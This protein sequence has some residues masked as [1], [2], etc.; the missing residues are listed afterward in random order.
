VFARR[1]SGR[2]NRRG[3]SGTKVGFINFTSFFTPANVLQ[4]VQSDLGVTSSGGLVSAWADQSGNNK[5]YTS[6][7]ALQ[8]SVS[9]G[10]NGFP[11]VTFNTASVTQLVSTLNLPAPGTTPTFIWGVFR[12][13]GSVA[14]NGAFLGG[15]ATSM[16][17][18]F[19]NSNTIDMY[20]GSFG[21]AVT[22]ALNVFNTFECLF[23]GSTTSYVK[24][25]TVSNTGSNVGNNPSSNRTLGQNGGFGT[26]CEVLALVYL[27]A[28]PTQ[29][30]LDAANA[31]AN[32]KYA[33]SVPFGNPASIIKSV[34]VAH[35]W[36]ADLGV[37]LSS[38]TVAAWA[39]QIGA[40]HLLQATSAKQPAYTAVDATF[41][42][43]PTIYTNAA[44]S[45]NLFSAA[46]VDLTG[47]LYII[48]VIKLLGA[49]N[50]AGLYGTPGGFAGD[51]ACIQTFG[52]YFQ[53]G[54]GVN[55]NAGPYT[56]VTSNWARYQ[57]R[58]LN[59][60][61]DY[62][63]FGADAKVTGAAC[64]LTVGTANSWGI[65]GS[66]LFG[67]GIYLSAGYRELIIC[68]GEPNFAELIAIDNYFKSQLPGVLV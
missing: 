43:S 64:P 42:N 36:R 55:A 62:V 58:R 25:G 9:T 27:N 32:I 38:G 6:I 63:K 49:N 18:R 59:N 50:S 37:T 16:Y 14:N 2:T 65:G 67:G 11:G 15:D 31:A 44:G 7:G 12:I 21:N 13:I 68:R 39:D 20:N 33:L 8:P 56:S 10:A 23:N 48:S 34:P 61:S 35:W 66:P 17:V 4:S 5:H 19:T 30:Q 46:N 40:A 53:S 22:P 51:G 45:N 26:N 57:D 47:P 52:N 1:V 24:Y 29:A 60:T 28:A 54:P 3:I 41:S